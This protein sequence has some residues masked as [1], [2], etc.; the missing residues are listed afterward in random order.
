MISDRLLNEVVCVNPEC[1]AAGAPHLSPHEDL[2][3][4][5]RCGR[6]YRL[7]DNAYIDLMPPAEGA[8]ESLYVSH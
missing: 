2:L 3:E 4:C 5:P 7:V 1:R 8:H 6:T